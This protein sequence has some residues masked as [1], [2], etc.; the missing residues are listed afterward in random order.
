MTED[1]LARANKVRKEMEIWAE[2]EQTFKR[3][4]NHQNRNVSDKKRIYMRFRRKNQA[5]IEVDFFNAG[6]IQIDQKFV[7]AMVSY[8]QVR[9]EQLQREMDAL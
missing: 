7:E 5:E 6:T 2:N 4:M 3:A 1:M 9:L 8:C